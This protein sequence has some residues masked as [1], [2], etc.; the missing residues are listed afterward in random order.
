MPPPQCSAVGVKVTERLSNEV[1]K[2]EGGGEEKKRME[3]EM[4]RERKNRREKD[5]KGNKSQTGR[6]HTNDSSL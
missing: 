1:R 4:K 5:W 2:R 3:K 6:N